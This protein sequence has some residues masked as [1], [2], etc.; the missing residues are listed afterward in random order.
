[1]RIARKS[2]RARHSGGPCQVPIAPA[3]PATPGA[4]RCALLPRD[5]RLGAVSRVFDGREKRRQR[6]RHPEAGTACR[7]GAAGYSG[8]PDGVTRVLPCASPASWASIP[9]GRPL[10]PFRESAT[11]CSGVPRG[12]APSRRPRARNCALAVAAAVAGNGME[13][14]R[15]DETIIARSTTLRSSRMLPGHVYRCSAVK[16]S[17]SIASMRLP[18]ALENSSTKRQTSRE[19]PRLRSRS[20]GT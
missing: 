16:L 2:H 13:R 20:G 17:R 3:I 5:E 11:Q 10:R 15:L 4:W 8:R 12:C 6:P 9:G 19:C 1:M 7:R 18:K 14:R